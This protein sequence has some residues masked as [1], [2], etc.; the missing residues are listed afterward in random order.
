LQ[1]KLLTIDRVKLENSL[2]FG[3]IR[4]KYEREDEIVESGGNTR[5]ENARK[6]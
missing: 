1:R 2:C 3:G 4:K 5:G 6:K